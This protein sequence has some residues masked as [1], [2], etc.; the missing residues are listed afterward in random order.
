MTQSSSQPSFCQNGCQLFRELVS[1]GL[2]AGGIVWIAATLALFASELIGGGSSSSTVG[3]EPGIF[4]NLIHTISVALGT[5]VGELPGYH[6]VMALAG[7][8]MIVQSRTLGRLDPW[9]MPLFASGGIGMLLQLYVGL[10][11]GAMWVSGIFLALIVVGL[12]LS[13]VWIRAI[14]KET[15]PPVFI[16]NQ[17]QYF[18]QQKPR[19]DIKTSN[20]TP[21][22]DQYDQVLSG[23]VSGQKRVPTDTSERIQAEN[24]SPTISSV[25]LP[26]LPESNFPSNVSLF[27]GV[28][29]QSRS[30]KEPLSATKAEVEDVGLGV[31]MTQ[32]MEAPDPATFV[33]RTEVEVDS[34][35]LEDDSIHEL[36]KTMAIER[37]IFLD[38]MK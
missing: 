38:D 10:G 15:K 29:K 14:K 21:A 17:G 13:G 22:N 12:L 20:R 26:P 7:A 24:P 4:A 36:E 19:A 5:L 27:P 1:G 31:D 8:L 18:I 35:T 2:L 23:M 25:D 3:I 34:V 16:D 6:M 11:G 9:K 33:E 30:Q 37:P 28:R 32:E